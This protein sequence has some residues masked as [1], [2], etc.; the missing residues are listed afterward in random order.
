MSNGH[1]A[2]AQAPRLISKAQA[3]NYCGV[4]PS[5]FAHWV[6]QGTLPKPVPGTNRWDQKAIDYRLDK[7]AGITNH[8][9]KPELEFDEMEAKIDARIAQR[10]SQGKKASR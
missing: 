6:K 4:S 1:N 3:A 8:E 7:L 2:L 9:T 10:R 5:A